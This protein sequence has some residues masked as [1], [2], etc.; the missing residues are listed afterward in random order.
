MNPQSESSIMG[1]FAFLAVSMSCPIKTLL[2]N[3]ERQRQKLDNK[4][5][6]GNVALRFWF[7]MAQP[8]GQSEI[9][10]KS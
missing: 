7:E 8:T 1:K 4:I 10:V 3:R 5:F 9:L 6:L 2:E